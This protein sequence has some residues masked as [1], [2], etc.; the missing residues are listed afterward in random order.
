M[1]SLR[2]N[3]G[4]NQ[5]LWKRFGIMQQRGKDC[6]FTACFSCKK[7]C[8][9][10]KTTSTSTI[11]KHKCPE[12]PQSG[13]MSVFA[14]NGVANTTDKKKV[15]LAAANFYAIDLR[16]FESVAGCHELFV[17]AYSNSFGH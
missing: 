15:T 5:A 9:F 16:P 3:H 10:K 17:G 13:T 8:T 1:F 2:K 4:Q 14:T 11:A 6:Q 7:V 12:E